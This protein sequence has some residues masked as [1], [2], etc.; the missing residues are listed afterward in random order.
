MKL[1]CIIVDDE[2][3]ARKSL[4][5]L[6]EQHSALELVAICEN[7]QQALKVLE[8]NEIDL[9]WLDVEMPEMTGFDLL[10]KITTTT[11]QVI[12]TTSKI[13]YAYDAFQYQVTDYLK[14]PITGPRFNLAVE[15]VL[16][17]RQKK[18]S[19]LQ[20]HN[21]IYIKHEGRYIRLPYSDIQ[22]VENVGDYVKIYTSKQ[23]YVIHTTMKS[24]EEKLGKQFLR[25]HRSYIVHLDKI[26]DIEENNLVIANKV[27]PISRANKSELMN[28]LNM[29]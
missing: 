20:Q 25:V 18:D 8:Q 14:K 3:M 4:Q 5:K 10:E 15:K 12:L 13:E 17:L 7:V 19:P 21:E 27:I 2:I 23:S 24:L 9:I 6:C 29:L 26:V 22:F 28:R 16:D 1:R 11:T